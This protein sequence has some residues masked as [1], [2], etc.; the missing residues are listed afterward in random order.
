MNRY[1]LRVAVPCP[2]YRAFD[3]LPPA[4]CSTPPAA[5]VRVRVPFGRQRLTGI[6]LDTVTQSDVPVDKLR[7]ADAVLDEAPLLDKQLM[8]LG[9]WAAAYYQHP[10]GEV[11]SQLLPGLLRQGRAPEAMGETRWRLTAAGK[12]PTASE[13]LQRAPRQRQLVEQ[14]AAAPQGLPT[15]QLSNAGQALRSLR[16]KDLVEQITRIPDAITEPAQPGPTLNTAQQQAVEAISEQSGQFNAFLLDGVTGS[17]KTEVY[18][19]AIRHVLAQ[20][21]QAMVLVPEIGLTPQT[22]ARFRERLGVPLAV[23]HSGLSDGERH[24]AW[25]AAKRGTARVIIGTRSA[26]WAPLPEPGLLIVDEE[27]DGSYKQQEGFRY[28][29]RDIAVLRAQKLGCPIVLG[30][31]TP[32]LESLHNVAAGRYQH[33]HLPERAGQAAHPTLRLLD[34]RGQY[35]QD[36]LSEPLLDAIARHLSDGGQ[37]LLFLNRRGYAPVLMCHACGWQADCGRC[38]AHLTLHR[39]RQRLLCHHCGFERGIPRQCPACGSLDLQIL[40]KG[41]ERLADHLVER[42]PHAGIARL[43]RDSIRKRGS[44][45]KV[46]SDVVRGRTR[47]LIGTQMLTKGH[48]FPG[49]TLV[50]VVDADAGLFGADFRAAEKLTQQIT[51]VAGRAGRADM[52]GEVLIQTHHP[53]HPLLNRLIHQGYTACAQELLAERQQTGLPPY[54]HLALLRAQAAQQ[55]AV[56]D[57]LNQ[58]AQQAKKISGT[59]MLLGPAPAP[60]ARKAGRQRGQLLLQASDRR[61]LQTFLSAWVPEL[62]TLPAARKVRWSIDVDPLDMS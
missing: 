42:F 43:D 56:D 6:L 12:Q 50:G 8:Q 35:L 39:R 45:D 60:L 62:G 52:P 5:G 15:A 58:A 53:E 36:G 57:F 16:D 13:A 4:D 21:K 27:H 59:P 1:L 32:A 23:L 41:T 17:G 3:Y 10:V 47:I 22:L 30:S 48:D 61:E 31:A 2:L 37:T 29:A 20:G 44:L 24:N 14:L 40:G 55:T 46:L 19:Q 54:A 7:P 38:D 51:Q 28:S 25:L 33:V 18:L 11:F 9:C 34:V 26:V 49:I